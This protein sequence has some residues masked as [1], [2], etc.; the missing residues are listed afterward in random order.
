MDEHNPV[1]A[2]DVYIEGLDVEALGFTQRPLKEGV[3]V[4]KKS[5]AGQPGY[6]PRLLLKLHLYGYLNRVRSSRNLE[7]ECQRDL[8]VCPAEQILRRQGVPR[9]EA[10]CKVQ[11]YISSESACGAC[12][13]RAR[14]LSP[15]SRCRE[16]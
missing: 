15:K 8:Y 4:G 6:S 12:P 7:K 1:R 16:I 3:V 2:I 9:S 10:G 13:Q 11:R 14:C 5:A